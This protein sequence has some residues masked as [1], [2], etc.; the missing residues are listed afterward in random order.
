[1]CVRARA[2]T[3]MHAYVCVWERKRETSL[4]WKI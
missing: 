1:V 4:H 3:C 2:R